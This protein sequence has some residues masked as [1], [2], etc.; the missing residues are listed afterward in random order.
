[1]K[2]LS[3]HIPSSFSDIQRGSLAGMTLP[4]VYLV[5]EFSQGKL[6][7]MWVILF[8]HFVICKPVFLP[9]HLAAYVMNKI[10]GV[11]SLSRCLFFL[12][13]ILI[14]HLPNLPVS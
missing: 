2:E 1:M 11:L 3:L 6:R 8:L 4:I 10:C 14:N 5:S 9:S 12:S 7:F 13:S